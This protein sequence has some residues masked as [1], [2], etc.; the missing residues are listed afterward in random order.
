M[1]KTL[2]AVR[3]I[4]LIITILTLNPLLVNAVQIQEN[5]TITILKVCDKEFV[6]SIKSKKI[7]YIKTKIEE[8]ISIQDY[9][10]F[11]QEDITDIKLRIIV[12]ETKNAKIKKG[13]HLLAVIKLMGDENKK[14]W[15]IVNYK[16]VNL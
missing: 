7:Y 10:N 3:I 11:L 2:Q 8:S 6:K 5:R 14:V 13:T 15:Q 1:K 4:T 12:D 9:K 16:I